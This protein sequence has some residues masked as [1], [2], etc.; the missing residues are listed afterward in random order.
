MHQAVALHQAG[1]LAEAEK[2]YRAVLAAEP[3][4]PDALHLLGLVFFHTKRYGEALPLI[5]QAIRIKPRQA[6]FHTNLGQVHAALQQ[7]ERAAAC[8]R[9]AVELDAK[10]PQ[11]WTNL[12]A[13]LHEIGRLDE[14]RAA[15]QKAVE[16][17]GRDAAALGVLG[18][19][20]KDLGH[21]DLAVS[22]LRQ[23]LALRPNH[24]HTLSNLGNALRAVGAWEEARGLLERA[25]A[26]EP[27]MAEAHWNLSMVLLRLCGNWGDWQAGWAEYEWRLRV[28]RH[29][30]RLGTGRPTTPSWD[31]KPQTD[32]TLLLWSEQ[33]FGDCIQFLRFAVLAA[34]RCGELI[35]EVPEPLARLAKATAGISRVFVAKM[36]SGAGESTSG[37]W[38]GHDLQAPLLSLPYLLGSG[39]DLLGGSV[40][41]LRA[42]AGLVS[43]WRARLDRASAGD[44]ARGRLVGLVW[45]GNEKPDPQRSM[46]LAAMAPLAGLAGVTF[47]SL[48]L[49]PHAAQ[50]P[51]A[52]M[53]LIDLTSYIGDFADTAALIAS[54]D[55]VVTIDSAAA[56]LAGA[57]GGRTYTLLPYV[58]D[59]RWGLSGDQSAWYPTMRLFRQ[60]RPD[61][62]SAA[63]ESA[64]AAISREVL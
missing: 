50:S 60:N 12:G 26:L 43:E 42:D 8:H 19:I 52:G 40:P 37:D 9:R 30:T 16:L 1:R 14:A 3:G 51:P 38:P 64:A 61:D 7:F 57:L 25:V 20:E 63:V 34:K 17:D 23:A 53:R 48:Q 62:W 13:A 10:L 24:A 33:G 18:N 32:K 54:L 31:G 15:A 6:E 44:G 5:G 59:W 49:G 2:I 55:A 35:L 39:D 36:N 47:V 28:P 4:N 41:Y 45:G 56:H 29:V 22:L 11:A 46:T 58:P 21:K 27:A